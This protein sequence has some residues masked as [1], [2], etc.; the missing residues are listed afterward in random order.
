MGS[1]DQA[2][3]QGFKPFPQPEPN[4]DPDPAEVRAELLAILARARAAPQEPWPAKEMSY[5]RTVFPQM[6]NWLPDEEAARLRS[7][8][9]TELERLGVASRAD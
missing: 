9:R 2:A 5:W 7:K 1:P 4:Y 3:P 8:F 6:A